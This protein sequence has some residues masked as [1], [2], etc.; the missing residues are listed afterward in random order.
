MILGKTHLKP[1]THKFPFR[2]NLPIQLP[3]SFEGEYGFIRYTVTVKVEYPADPS[4]ELERRITVIK[5]QD[6]NH[7]DFQVHHSDKSN[8]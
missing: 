4:Q 3:S 7:P 1:G 6:I 5:L 2:F 8:L